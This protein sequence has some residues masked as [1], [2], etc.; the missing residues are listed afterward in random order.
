MKGQRGFVWL[1]KRP[2]FGLLQTLVRW[3]TLRH[4]RQLLATLSDAALKDIG[5]SRADVVRESHWHFWED[6]LRK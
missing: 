1:A 2:L 5:L 4:E 3:Q 6:P